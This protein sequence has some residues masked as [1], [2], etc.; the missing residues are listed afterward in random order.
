MMASGLTPRQR[1]TLDFIAGFIR[2]HGHS[3]SYQQISEGVPLNSKGRVADV[4]RCLVERQHITILPKRAR[5]ISI[6]KGQNHD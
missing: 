6:L 2:Q 3:P 1:E 4:L 5:S